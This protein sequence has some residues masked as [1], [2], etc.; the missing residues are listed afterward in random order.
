MGDVTV[1]AKQLVREGI[2]F[3]C[4]DDFNNYV[5]LETNK[6]TYTKRQANFRNSL[7]E[8]CFTTCKKN[9]I[10]I[11]DVMGN[12]LMREIG[13]DKIQQGA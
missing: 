12:I 9:G 6:K 2:N 5:N 3:H 13:L 1:F 8:Q 7:M 4:D 10:D 11:Y